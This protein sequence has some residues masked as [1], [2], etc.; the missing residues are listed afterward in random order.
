M[1]IPLSLKGDR[2]YLVLGDTSNSLSS[3]SPLASLEWTE[4][5]RQREEIA[6]HQ[7]EQTP[8]QHLYIY[9]SS[10]SLF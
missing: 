10:R 3:F 6:F 5:L 8:W 9:I 2:E 4:R 7:S 1:T